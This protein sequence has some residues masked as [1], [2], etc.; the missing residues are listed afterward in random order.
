M[1]SQTLT[2]PWRRWLSLLVAM[3]VGATI[4]VLTAPPA[5][6][7]VVYRIN[8]GGPQNVSTDPLWAEDSV[9]SPSEY[10]NV[11]DTGQNNVSPAPMGTT[12]TRD[13]SVPP[14]VEVPNPV[15][16]VSRFD[17]M[18]A[19][20]LE[21]DFPVDNGTYEVRLFFVETD[22][23]A[24]GLRVFDVTIDGDVVLDD[25]DI[26][27]DVGHDVAVMKTFE[28]T[29]DDGN[30]D[31]DFGHVTENPVIAAID[32][33]AL[34]TPV[35]ISVS[36][37]PV[38]LSAE[39]DSQDTATVTVT[40]DGTEAVTV[41]STEITGADAGDFADDYPDTDTP[42]NPSESLNF[43]VTFNA[44]STPGSSTAS[45]G[46]TVNGE[47]FS[48]TLEGT[49]TF[50]DLSAS[51]GEVD[52]GNVVVDSSSSVDVTVTNVGDA[53][54]SVTG[55]S[56][57]GAD[58]DA[59]SVDDGALPTDLDPGDSV[60]L[61]VTFSPTEDGAQNATLTVSADVGDVT[62]DLAG[63]ATLVDAGF[64]DIAGSTFI[65][66]INWL[67]A[68][69]ITKGCNPPMNDEFCPKDF[70]TRGQ[71]AAFLHRALDDVL[72][73]GPA[74]EFVDDDGNTFEADIE[75]LGATGVTK[76]CN[77]PVND[78]FCPDDFVTRGQMAAFLH[79]ALD[80]ILT[81][82]PDVEFVDDDGNTFEADIE[83]LGATGVTKGCNPP[84]ND[85]FCPNDNVTREQ[86]AAFLYRALS[87]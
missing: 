14:P 85:Q 24:D 21:W 37:N 38:E 36:P 74:V 41:A 87:S 33:H 29:V 73:P 22:V 83:W 40:N 4:I 1:H 86:M 68:T 34:D 75:W 65:T 60:V 23:E 63:T 72:V 56:V 19:G 5:Q 44:P 31:I 27:A 20:E 46:V 52:F 58:A 30:I 48:T 55:A 35:D 17:P 18:G 61:E 53:P 26:H 54:A 84:V 59:F 9:T 3:A 67:A 70:V 6:A 77:P 47:V 76:G 25:Y 64:T 57:G 10:N 51:P 71:M 13:A 42:L 8:A 49:A 15:L 32:I 80:G 16:L 69:G 62:V 43:E 81:P 7:Q 66:E 82:G 2:V 39:V 28:T 11:A 79:R 12:L 50:G 45:L 78:E